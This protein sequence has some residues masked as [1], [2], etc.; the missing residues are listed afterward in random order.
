MKVVITG[1]AGFLGRKLTQALLEGGTLAGPGEAAERIDKLVLFDSIAPPA[2]DDPR[3]ETRTGDVADPAA[4]AAAIGDDA[5][6][7]FHL[8]AVVSGA[9]EADF[10]L[11]YRVNLDGTRNVLE[12]ARRLGHRPRVLFTSSI[13][14]Y[15]GTDLPAVVTDETPLTPL[16]S[17]GSGADR[18]RSRA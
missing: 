12:A 2:T 18:S 8:A 13:A 9:A 15:G 6:T 16:T 11:G 14:V 7:I 5:G 1:A 4:V 3:V 17:Y 10:D